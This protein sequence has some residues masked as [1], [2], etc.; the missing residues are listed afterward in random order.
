MNNTLLACAGTE[1]ENQ[2]IVRRI[3][4]DMASG[5]LQFENNA[6]SGRELPAASLHKRYSALNAAFPDYAI[7]VNKLLSK[8]DKVMASYTLYGTQKGALWGMP[9]TNEKMTITGIDVFRL[10]NGEIKEHWNVAHQINAL[11]F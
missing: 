3:Y 1:S 9:A 4:E 6:S 11:P 7:R 10:N 8:G 2:E 5:K